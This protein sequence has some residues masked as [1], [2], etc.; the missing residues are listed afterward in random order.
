MSA[1][2]SSRFPGQQ[3]KAG[4][5]EEMAPLDILGVR[6]AGGGGGFCLVCVML[7]DSQEVSAL[8]LT[9]PWDPAASTVGTA[10]WTCLAVTGG[11]MVGMFLPDSRVH[12]FCQPSS[13][14]LLRGDQP[15]PGFL[16]RPG[17]VVAVGSGVRPHRRAGERP[18]LGV[19]GRRAKVAPQQGLL[20]THRH[21]LSPFHFKKLGAFIAFLFWGGFFWRHPR[22]FG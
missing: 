19:T 1:G 13:G 7:L 11:N 22:A 15:C 3:G 2:L 10:H 18:G 14:H 5:G 17:L 4:P 20:P 21:P 16:P 9:V 6:G 8:P 12:A